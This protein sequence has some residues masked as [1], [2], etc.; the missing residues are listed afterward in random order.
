M[1]KYIIFFPFGYTYLS[2]IKSIPKFTSFLLTIPIPCFLF[3]YYGLVSIEDRFPVTGL[4]F[5]WGYINLYIFY[6][7]GYIENDIKT[8][9]KE[10]N[11]TLRIVGDLYHIIDTNYYKIIVARMMLF[12]LSTLLLYFLTNFDLI[13]KLV[14]L[15]AVTSL[16]YYL[17]NNIRNAFKVLTF[18]CLSASR[19][20]FPLFVFS[21]LIPPGKHVYIFLSVF[22]YTIPALFIYSTKS[23]KFTRFLLGSENKYKIIYYAITS[24]I[25]TV[26]YFVSDENNI[27]LVMSCLLFYMLLL[28][29]LKKML[30]R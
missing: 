25:F 3:F 27:L 7:N 14:F 5:I 21:H 17:H 12:S 20:I 15:S 29:S 13:L 23:F 4:L 22:I 24:L 6:E 1:S 19:F 28:N 18:F 26:L 8:V 11:P 9:K 16:F 10:S 2:R 30:N